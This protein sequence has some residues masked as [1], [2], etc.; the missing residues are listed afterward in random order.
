MKL[1]IYGCSHTGA[2]VTPWNETWPYHLYKS[3]KIH[4][5]NFAIGATSTQF[6]Y[7]LFEN[8]VNNFDKFIFQFTSPYRLTKYI[9]PIQQK[10]IKK[11]SFFPNHSK[12]EA[13]ELRTSDNL[14]TSTPGKFTEEYKKWISNDNGEILEHYQKICKDVNRHKKCLYAFYWI[15]DKT[16]V[17]G[18]DIMQNNFPDIVRPGAHL[19]SQENQI[20]ANYIKEK[21]KL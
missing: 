7:D 2:G 13:I 10:K 11:Y 3:K 14:E 19:D 12:D 15:K 8:S 18:I 9:R 4:I 20:I 17:K 21:C 5:S 1:A 16:N 6:Q